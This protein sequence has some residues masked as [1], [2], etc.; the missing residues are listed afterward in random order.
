MFIDDQTFIQDGRTYRRALLRNSYRDKGKVRH[1]TIA[2]LSQCQ[3]DEIDAI[4]LALKHKKNLTELVDIKGDIKTRQGLSVGSLWV[5]SLLSK[6]IGL[7]GALGKSRDAKL[8]LWMVFANIIAQGSRLSA[9]RLAGQHAVCDIL[10]LDAFNEDDL[11]NALTWLDEH[12]EKIEKKLF[13]KHCSDKPSCFYLYDVTSSYLEGD[14]NA[15][16]A[17]GYNRDGKKSKK[18]IV[19]GLITDEDGWPISI[20]VFDGN[21]N[22][23]STFNSQI[24]KLANR[25]GVKDVVMVGDRGMIKK[26][27]IEELPEDF[28]YITAITKPQIEALKN[29][30]IIQLSFFDEKVYEISQGDVRYILR[31]NPIRAEEIELS[32]QSKLSSLTKLLDNQN[33]YLS[34]HP[35]AQAEVAQRKVTEK[36]KALKIDKWLDVIAENRRLSI[37]INNEKK[38]EASRLD[39][40]YVIKTNLPKEKACANTVHDR[41]KSLAEVEI[42][43]RTM[44]T[45]LLEMRGI[46]VRTESHTRAHVFTIMLSYLLA[47]KLRR[48]WRDIEVTIEEGITELSSICG[49]EINIADKISSQTIPEP[50]NLGKILLEK[51]GVTLPDALPCRK[52]E[53]VTRKKLVTRRKKKIFQWDT[54]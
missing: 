47:Y 5:L 6:R 35:R 48:L 41:Y 17:Y 20:E 24:E 27:Q 12:Q 33:K 31:R 21:T 23:T 28:K 19:I 36:A 14:K 40:C 46:F 34:E 15:L 1:N 18:Q 54:P 37:S 45:V 49:L 16:G 30:G 39:G 22:D 3:D 8:A 38:E 10:N 52:I 2:N 29:Q 42:A 51:V 26:T 7:T 13:K 53:V 9:V 4:K 50:R 11:Y 43:F 44:K 32:R 25:F